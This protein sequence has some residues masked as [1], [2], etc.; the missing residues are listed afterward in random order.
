MPADLESGLVSVSGL[1]ENM[2]DPDL[3]NDSWGLLLATAAENHSSLTDRSV[4]V[5][6]ARRSARANCGRN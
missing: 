1:S 2:K 6:E 5:E 4:A 3:M